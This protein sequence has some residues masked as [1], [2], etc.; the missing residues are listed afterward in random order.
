MW[1]VYKLYIVCILTIFYL[2]IYLH[3]YS[4]SA[5]TNPFPPPWCFSVTPVIWLYVYIVKTCSAAG[6]RWTR[7]VARGRKPVYPVSPP[8]WIPVPGSVLQHAP[9]HQ[10][11]LSV[12]TART[13][14]FFSH[15]RSFLHHPQ[16][17]IQIINIMFCL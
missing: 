17:W 13:L 4:I 16:P 1:C 15:L 6:S 12:H 2:F 8:G 9:H 3:E 11:Y 10:Y 7:I 5:Y 14:T